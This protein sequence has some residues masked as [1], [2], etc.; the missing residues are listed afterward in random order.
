[1]RTRVLIPKVKDDQRSLVVHNDRH[2][3][4][5][6]SYRTVRNIVGFIHGGLEPVDR[7]RITVVVSP[8]PGEGKTSL[9]VNMAAAFVDAGQQ[10]VVVN[11][12]FRRPRLAALVTASPPPPLPFELADLSRLDPSSLLAPTV[13][14]DLTMLAS[15]RSTVRQANWPAPPLGWYRSWPIQP[16]RS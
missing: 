9:A 11:T 16:G 7:A 5:S 3:A 6:D 10:T 12:D 15:A 4:L 2:D 1:M 13:T 14:P 8:G